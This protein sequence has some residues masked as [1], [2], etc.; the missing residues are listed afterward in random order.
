M[1]FRK[2]KVLFIRSFAAL[3]VVAALLLLLER[4]ELLPVFTRLGGATATLPLPA[5]KIGRE[6]QTPRR[7]E[8]EI[9]RLADRWYEELLA[10]HPEMAVA[11]K[12]VPDA[13]NGFLKLLDFADRYGPGGGRGLDLP[14]DIRKMIGSGEGWNGT[15]FAE[16]LRGNRALVDEITAIGLLP[17]QSIKGIDPSR[18]VSF[19]ARVHMDCSQILH[20]EA[21]LLLEQGD[22]ES[23]LRSMRAAMGLTTHLDEIETPFLFSESVSILLRLGTWKFANDTL[24]SGD[25]A[26]ADLR[27]WRET[28]AVGPSGPEELADLFRG[29]WHVTVKSILLPQ[30]L[31]GKTEFNGEELRH[32]DPDALVEAHLAY[33]QHMSADMR[34]SDL[35]GLAGI[36]AAPPPADQ[37]SPESKELM[38]LLFNG[39]SAWSKGWIRAQ[40]AGALA[41]AAF[42]AG[43][44]EEILVE[45]V[46]GK[47]F[48]FDHNAGTIAM[49]DAPMLNGFDIKPMK[50]PGRR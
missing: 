15:R 21:R 5:S 20:S 40:C 4:N 47:P 48:V 33:Y 28:L 17:Q 49:P 24:L 36:S 38:A 22:E 46:S 26:P 7:S 9:R 13:E 42:A 31:G 8:K 1:T 44:G 2:G 6:Q 12:D 3:L 34:T 39:T 23:A 43:M 50:I 25:H 41:E 35:A 29:E 11:Y 14:D 16:W 45:P 27:A 32:P 18:F 10:K 19:S 30:L 37:L